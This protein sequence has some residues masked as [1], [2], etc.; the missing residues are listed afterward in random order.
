MESVK[1]DADLRDH[2]AIIRL[3]SAID[4]NLINKCVIVIDELVSVY[5]YMKIAIE[6]ASPGGS[7]TSLKYFLH[8]IGEWRRKGVQINTRALTSAASAAAQLLSV[9][10]ERRAAATTRLLYHNSRFQIGSDRVFEQTAEKAEVITDRLKAIDEDA[11]DE[12]ADR[13]CRI[14]KDDWKNYLDGSHKFFDEVELEHAFCTRL[15]GVPLVRPLF[16]FLPEWNWDWDKGEVTPEGMEPGRRE[17]WHLVPTTAT[18]NNKGA[19][20]DVANVFEPREVYGYWVRGVCG[21]ESDRIDKVWES[22]SEKQDSEFFNIYTLSEYT[23]EEGGKPIEEFRKRLQKRIEQDANASVSLR[24]AL[25]GPDDEYVRYNDEYAKELQK[26]VQVEL[27][28]YWSLK[29]LMKQILSDRGENNTEALKSRLRILY[30]NLC[31]MDTEISPAVAKALG[32]IDAVGDEEA[33]G[34]ETDDENEYDRNQHDSSALQVKEWKRMYPNG[35]AWELLCRHTLI[36]GETGSGKTKSGILPILRAV[37]GT[38]CRKT[39]EHKPPVGCL[40]VIDPKEEICS[41]LERWADDNPNVE[42]K[43]LGPAEEGKPVPKWN[44]MADHPKFKDIRVDADFLGLG[45]DIITGIAGLVPEHPGNRLLGAG[46]NGGNE[47]FWHDMA[48][49]LGTLFIGM[50]IMLVAFG[51]KEGQIRCGDEDQNT[52]NGLKDVNESHPLKRS[53]Q[54]V[55]EGKKNVLALASAIT[56]DYLLKY[57]KTM[58]FWKGGGSNH[59]GDFVDGPESEVY[60]SDSFKQ[61]KQ[62]YEHFRAYHTEETRTFVNMLASTRQVFLHVA[63]GAFCEGVFFGVEPEWDKNGEA[64]KFDELVKTDRDKLTVLTYRPSLKREGEYLAR[65]LKAS[66][67]SAVLNDS[68][69]KNPEM[70]F[71][72]LVGYVADEAHRFITNDPTHGEQSFLDTC[73]SFGG[74]CVL[75]TQSVESMAY[76]L[77]GF[78]SKRASSALDVLL[79]NTA[80]KVIFRSTG[81]DTQA[82]SEK[83]SRLGTWGYVT[84]RRPLSSLRPGECFASLA[85][86][87]FVRKQIE[88]RRE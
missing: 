19:L 10:D 47:A 17:Q 32:L 28:P 74:F 35:I 79:N 4:D 48:C 86:G 46:T 31:L 76:S 24:E 63:D 9:C 73:R 71:K 3:T 70:K 16:Y 13:A 44:L 42:I 23:V 29:L 67:F 56:D 57:P 64:I 53:Y 8:A 72:Q 5:Q 33:Y 84:E 20:G 51:D 65:S 83:M 15:F 39:D 87:R 81:M 54:Q 12:L 25:S 38:A 2:E 61:L 66:F 45:K 59:S 21:K 34:R 82:R 85:D 77:Q 6:I 30:G 69:R 11:I 50:A 43:D 78:D 1:L 7:V 58:G 62:K 40:L 52:W 27:A 49:D 36:L 22:V 18:D 41:S 14:P 37:C 88:L 60:F 80:T 75:A 55:R 26:S 68:D